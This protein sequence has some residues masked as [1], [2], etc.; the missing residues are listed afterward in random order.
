MAYALGSGYSH[1]IYDGQPADLKGRRNLKIALA[2]FQVDRRGGKER[3]CLAIARSLAER[4]HDVTIVTTSR[5]ASET[6]PYRIV[7][8][9]RRG[10]T[11]HALARNFARKAM[12]YCSEVGSD[13]CLAFERIPG[14]EFYYAADN[15]AAS[16]VRGVRSLLPRGRI[17]L[18][19]ERG[20]FEQS[21]CP[22]F[23]FLTEQQ[24]C[25]FG[26][27]YRFDPSHSVVLPLILHDDRYDMAA[28]GSDPARIR[29][30][31]EL[32]ATSSVAIS[33][34]VSSALDNKGVDRSLVALA[35]LPD[36]YL[37][38]V[39]SDDRRLKR[40]VKALGLEQRVRIVP[41]ASNIIEL[42]AA[43]DVLVH[44]ARSEAAGQ[45]IGEALLAATPAIISSVC[46]YA[47]CVERSG[48]GVVLEEPFRQDAFEQAISGT[49]ARLPVA[50]AAAARESQRLQHER[51]KWLAVIGDEIERRIG[52]GSR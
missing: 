23:F 36:L 34:A 52:S 39:G 27:L 8:V 47:P 16:K 6:R 20:V 19:L 46:G 28:A 4:G 42:I 18:A 40:R 41:H 35:H 29:Q 17:R 13:A 12:N 43:A 38:V 21:P 14:A 10:L 44:P 11:N 49:L 48:A 2:L 22:F 30:Q 9:P 15:P 7:T 3:D 37:V 5:P 1:G 33:I 51:G 31:L 24:R 26:A 25:Q 50:R 32:P 45:V